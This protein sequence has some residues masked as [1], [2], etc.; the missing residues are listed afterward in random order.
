M[1]NTELAVAMPNEGNEKPSESTS[2]EELFLSHET[3]LL[4]YAGK[5]TSNSETAQDIV[6]EAFMKL[7]VQFDEVR[8]PRAWLYRTV[9][10]LALNQRRAGKKIVPLERERT[11]ACNSEPAD[12]KPLPNEQAERF[13]V[14]SRTRDCLEF[15]DQ[16]SRELIRLKFEED[17]SYKEIS[18][19]TGLSVSNV[20]Y[21]LHHTLKTLAAEL[22]KSGVL[23]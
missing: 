5:L 2:L 16:R 22:A 18:A 3:P 23:V 12:L 20:G 10:N 1:G 13:E 4:I 19:R 6:Q 7:H 17:L 21:L 14:I 9:H 11:E 15:L 8:Q